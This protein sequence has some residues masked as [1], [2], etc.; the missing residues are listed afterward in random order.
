M[1]GRH[2]VQEA[3]YE[4]VERLEVVHEAHRPEQA[5]DAEE[6]EG[7]RGDRRS[8]VTDRSD[9]LK[10]ERQSHDENIE[11]PKQV[12]PLRISGVLMPVVI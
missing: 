1:R 12:R 5:E 3:L 10:D 11:P 8:V 9:D 6:P 7:R 4:H 2:G